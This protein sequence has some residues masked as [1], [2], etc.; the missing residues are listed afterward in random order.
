MQ[1]HQESKV[2]ILYF[3][4]LVSAF[5]FVI[6]QI[7]GDRGDSIIGPKGDRGAPGLPGK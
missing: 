2:F 7:A 4:C 6:Q 5:N 1:D 3:F